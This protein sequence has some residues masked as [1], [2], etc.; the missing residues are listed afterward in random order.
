MS[1]EEWMK[2]LVKFSLENTGFKKDVNVLS[3][4]RIPHVKK[5][6]GTFCVASE[7]GREK[8]IKKVTVLQEN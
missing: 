5:G 3:L 1:H 2:G 8:G 4:F 6:L 7:C